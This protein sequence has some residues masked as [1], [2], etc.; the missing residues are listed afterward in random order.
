MTNKLSLD[1]LILIRND[2]EI[3]TEPFTKDSF[4]KNGHM[5]FSFPSSSAGRNGFAA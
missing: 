3:I 1:A 4:F 5:Q 2:I